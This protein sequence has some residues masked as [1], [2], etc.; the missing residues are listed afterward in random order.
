MAKNEKNK[1]GEGT[2]VS[3]AMIKEEPAGALAQFEDYGDDAGAGTKHLSAEEKSIPFL[4]LLQSNSPEVEKQTVPGAKAGMFL[5]TVTK[6]LIDGK[7]GLIIQPVYADRSI[8][9][10]KDRD[11]GGGLVGSH[12]PNSPEALEAKD[13]HGGNFFSTKENPV[14]RGE[15]FM[16]DTRYLYCNILTDDGEEFAGAY[17]LLAASKSKIKPT[18]NFISSIDMLRGKPPLFAARAHLTSVVEIQKGSGK[19]FYN[20]R[21]MPYLPG[22]AWREV[23]IPGKGP[24]GK[25]HPLLVAGRQFYDAITGGAL[26]ADFDTQAMDA[27]AAEAAEEKRHF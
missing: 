25:K 3:E 12:Q 21:F 8:V 10:W 24:D 14:R 26:K 23:L 22:K 5:N 18:Q 27:E 17:F 9:E 6:E 20:V 19:E 7:K 11:K 4:N 1:T 13:A 2:M 15:N 16:V